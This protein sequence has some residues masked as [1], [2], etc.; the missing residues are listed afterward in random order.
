M[1]G[2]T[3]TRQD[4]PR[5]DYELSYEAMRTEG[6]DFFAAATFPVGK[7][8]ITLVNGGWGGNVTGLS[9]LNGMDASENETTCSI[10]YEDKTWYRFRIHVTGRAIRCWIDDKEI[11]AVD[12]QD[13]RVST[14]LETRVNEPLGFATWKTGGACARSRSARSRP[15]RSRPRTSPFDDSPEAATRERFATAPG[16]ILAGADDLAAVAARELLV[17]AV[18]RPR[19]ED[20][21][22]IGVGRAGGESGRR[23]ERPGVDRVLEEADRAVGERE[24]GAAGMVARRRVSQNWNILADGRHHVEGVDRVERGEDGVG[25]DRVAPP[26]VA[27]AGRRRACRWPVR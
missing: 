23:V 26:A 25:G 4:L 12:Y 19:G 13:R 15:T 11:I 14:R 7:A 1:T 20:Q 8:Y 18:L 9:S 21:V 22:S 5:V 16:S 6:G 2:I 24:V 10:K 27:V 17:D 3:T